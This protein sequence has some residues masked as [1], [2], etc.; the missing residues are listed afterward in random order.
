MGKSRRL[1]ARPT[2]SISRA[3]LSTTTRDRPKSRLRPSSPSSTA[4][5]AE[6]THSQMERG[7]ATRAAFF[8]GGGNQWLLVGAQSC[9]AFSPSETN[10]GAAS[11]RPYTA[12]SFQGLF[13]TTPHRARP[14]KPSPADRFGRARA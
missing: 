11:L 2:S 14:A 13:F 4:R 12:E 7:S 9:C 8:L 10:L 6:P 5:K 3:R 1:H